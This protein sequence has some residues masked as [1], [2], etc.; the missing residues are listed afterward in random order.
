M[1]FNTLV[2]A[3]FGLVGVAS[4][5]WAKSEM[6]WVAAEEKGFR[7]ADLS[8]IE[9]TAP[10]KIVTDGI[11]VAPGVVL[12]SPAIA[13]PKFV[14]SLELPADSRNVAV[15]YKGRKTDSLLFLFQDD[16]GT[17]SL[18]EETTEGLSQPYLAKGTYY[19]AVFDGWSLRQVRLR[20]GHSGLKLMCVNV[21]GSSERGERTLFGPRVGTGSLPQEATWVWKLKDF[22]YTKPSSIT[23]TAVN[24]YEYGYDRPAQLKS[25]IWN[26]L[27]NTSSISKV[28]A[29]VRSTLNDV[30]WQSGDFDKK[31]DVALELP[32]L[33]EGTYFLELSGHDTQ[34]APGGECRL[35]YQVLRD[36]SGGRPV[37]APLS[38]A[39]VSKL[40]IPSLKKTTADSAK[41]DINVYSLS[42]MTTHFDPAQEK[43]LPT[44]SLPA[45]ADW[46]KSAGMTPGFLIG[47]NEFEPTP[48][49]YQ[50]NL[51]DGLLAFSRKNGQSAWLGIGF[52]G[53]TLP[54]W[55]WFEELMDQNQ[56]TIQASY[57]YVTPF[58]PRFTQ[59]HQILLRELIGHYRG[60]PDVGGYLVYAGPSEGFLT[61]TPPSIC[62]YS[63]AARLAFRIY[64]QKIYIAKLESLNASWGTS[65]KSWQEVQPPQPDWTCKWETSAAWMDFHRFK[66]D[67]V[68]DRMSELTT[69]ARK[70]DPQRPMMAYGKEGFGST[71]RLA[72]VFAASQFRYSNGGGETQS[73]YIQTCI[74]RNHGVAAN[75]EGH[76][77]MP[78]IGSVAMVIANSVWAG[79]FEGQ[80][81]MWGLVWAKQKHEGVAE[82]QEMAKWTAG[83]AAHQEELNR[84]RAL[85]PW[86]AY[87]DGIQSMLQARSFRTALYPE[88]SELMQAAGE[89][90]HNLCSWVDDDSSLAAMQAYRLLV[91]S[92]SH[93]LQPQSLDTLLAYVRSGG[94]F[95]A[96]TETARYLTGNAEEA[97]AL[98]K[99][100]G[101]RV[102]EELSRGNVSDSTGELTVKRL[103]RVEWDSAS[104]AKIEKSDGQGRPLLW[105]IPFGKGKVLL[106]CGQI[107]FGKS[108]RYLQR[109]VNETVGSP[110]TYR[111]EGRQVMMR[112]LCSDKADY[113]PFVLSPNDRELN[114]SFAELNAEGKRQVTV[115][116]IAPVVREVT[117]VITGQSLPVKQGIVSGE[118][119]PGLIYIL[120]VP[121]LSD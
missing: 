121:R 55:L 87:F 99:A 14:L 64:L 46:S 12:V 103:D 97:H 11:G 88:V 40:A 70:A 31:S 111:V 115:S 26:G 79:T 95:L 48:G 3:L 84:S 76:Y 66:A 92:S 30:I 83:L 62:D 69:L 16:S 110:I 53:D 119:V 67:F 25:W 85:Q 59:A 45:L 101:G 112:P 63:P 90:M 65:Y 86:A 33:P 10:Y 47:W 37:N 44:T 105:S 1:K 80:N 109:A 89:G 32:R 96:S 49:Q 75:P 91:D 4:S 38:A 108:I 61:D 116:G 94:I 29:V 78:N 72:K 71:G 107:H 5:A 102:A 22:L 27:L 42:W 57:H 100:L 98:V 6:R 9:V 13:A 118:F 82:Y 23:W 54:D 7:Y 58:G 77:V 73:S 93:V 41:P 60:N 18:R 113:L 15:W 68:V 17:F 104:G 36:D 51:L 81:I 74:M 43:R 52:A 2:I 21:T 35:V 120:K 106:A 34:G 114:H 117:E 50:W 8:G 24:Y 28:K 39:S 19:D 20:G 56:K